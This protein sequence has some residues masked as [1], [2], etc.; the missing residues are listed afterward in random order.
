MTRETAWVM[1]RVMTRPKMCD[2]SDGGSS[3]TFSNMPAAE[4]VGIARSWQ[5]SSPCLGRRD[6]PSGQA[7]RSVSAGGTAPPS[8][9]KSQLLSQSP[10]AKLW[11]GRR[12]GPVLWSLNSMVMTILLSGTPDSNLFFSDA[13]G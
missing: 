9:Y 10:T 3:Y 1:H 7:V 6:G 12:I 5:L 11:A 13:L 8:Q 4:A 2:F